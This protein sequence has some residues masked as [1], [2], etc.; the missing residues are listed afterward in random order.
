MSHTEYMTI[1]RKL[2]QLDDRAQGYSE[3]ELLLAEQRLAVSLP[4]VLRDYYLSLGKNAIVNENHNRLLSPRDLYITP[5]GYLFFYEENQAVAVWGIA[6]DHLQEANPAVYGSYDTD[7]E[8]WWADSD[9]LEHFLLSMAYWNAALGGLKHMAMAEQPPDDITATIER[10]WIEHKGIT[11]Q[12]LHFFTSDHSDILALTTDS[13][14]KVNG[15]YVASAD[16]LKYEQIVDR[17]PISW[18]YRSDRDQY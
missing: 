6:R 16:P 12:Y 15:L 11:N 10:H 8:E 14:G 13:E 1:I 5:S 17:L 9:S 3:Q 2:Y 18:D 7:R 4:E